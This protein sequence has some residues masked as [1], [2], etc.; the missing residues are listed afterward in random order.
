MTDSPLGCADARAFAP[1]HSWDRNFFLA[2]VGLACVGIIRGFGGDIA[3][4]LAA[5]RPAYPLIV[6][7][8]AV[9]FVSWLALFTVQVLLV[10]L[11]R[12]PVH[13]KLGM[14]MVWLA[15]VMV[16][17]GPSA[18]LTVQHRGMNDPDADPAFLSIQF[19]DIL[20]FAGLAAAGIALRKAPS[21]HKRLMLLSTLHITDAGFARWL[22]DG[23]HHLL[24]DSFWALWVQLYFGPSLLIL[25]VGAYDLVTRRRLDAAYV[26]GTAWAF[27]NQ[28]LALI[29]Y[30]APFWLACSK[31]IIAIWP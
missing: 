1:S 12:L 13:R 2:M 20:A 16:V 19:T 4:H 11:K 30:G 25:G 18:A 23:F 10:R 3:Q 6:H 22:A 7:F 31:K 28:M 26:I 5:H 24:G 17:L 9:A 15:L 8:H 21:A 29:L 27:A 14:A